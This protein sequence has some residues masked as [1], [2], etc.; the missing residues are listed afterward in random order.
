MKPLNSIKALQR[1][2]SG[3]LVWNF[4]VTTL[5]SPGKGEV[6]SASNFVNMGFL[7]YR[8]WFSIMPVGRISLMVSLIDELILTN[9]ACCGSTGLY[10]SK[11]NLISSPAGILHA[12][13]SLSDCKSWFQKP[14]LV[15]PVISGTARNLSELVSVPPPMAVSI[16]GPDTPDRDSALR[17]PLI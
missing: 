1:V 13:N 3:T 16:I 12:T 8:G 17:R 6:C 11:Q 4:K 9:C 15:V 14:R 7:T 5:L 10:S 2:W